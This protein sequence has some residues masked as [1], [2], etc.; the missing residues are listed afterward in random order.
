MP[1]MPDS[2]G[3]GG[4]KGTRHPGISCGGKYRSK[5]VMHDVFTRSSPPQS[6]AKHL[7]CNLENALNEF[8]FVRRP[9]SRSSHISI[10]RMSA[11]FLQNFFLEGKQARTLILVTQ[12]FRDPRLFLTSPFVLATGC[13]RCSSNETR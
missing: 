10:R 8:G 2:V 12:T 13:K 5:K 6:C 1:G 11:L 3:R 4:R 7:V 9:S